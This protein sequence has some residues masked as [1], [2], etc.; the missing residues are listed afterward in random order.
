[1]G[2]RSETLRVTGM[3]C[4]NCARTIEKSVAKVA[5]VTDARVN[6]A[7]EKLTAV[8]DPDAVDLAAIEQAVKKAGYGVAPQPAAIAPTD[9]GGAAQPVVADGDEETNARLRRFWFSAAFTL[10]LFALAMGGMLVGFEPAWKPGAEFLLALPIAMYAAV[11]FYD[12]AWKALRNKS[13][14]MDT[15]VALGAGSAFAY[16]AIEVLFPHVFPG[17]ALYFE[18]GAV[19]VTLI[20]LGK[21]FEARSKSRASSAIKRLLQLGAKSA[22]VER[23]GAWVDVPIEQ[24]RPGDRM[25]VKPGERVPTDGRVVSGQSAVDESMVTGESLPVEKKAGDE[26]VGATVLQNGSLVVE[27]TR[28]GSDTMLAQ[29]VR[30]VEDAQTSR[31]PVERLVDQVSRFFV[32]VV[33]VVAILAGVAWYVLGQ[34][35]IVSMGYEPLSFSLL[36]TIAVLIIACPCAMGLAT[37]TAI[38]VGTGRGAEAGILLKG[39]DVLERARKVGV[40]LLDKTGTITRGKPDVTDVIPYGVDEPDLLRAAAAVESRSEHPLASAIVARAKAQGLAL[41]DVAQFEAIGG[42][43]VR[44]Q[45]EGEP[46]AVGRLSYLRSLGTDTTQAEAD[47]ARLQSEGKSVVGVAHGGTLVGLVAIADT[48]KPESAEAVRRMRAMGLDVVMVTGDNRGSAEAIARQVGITTVEAEVLPQD[49]A[50]L[51]KKYQAA[52]QQVAFAGDGINDAPALAQSDLGIAMGAG[53]DIAIETGH[54]VLVGDDLRDVAAAVDLSRKTLRKIW[55]NL[56]WAFGYNVLLIPVAAGLLFAVPVF[57]ERL[58][59][60]PMLAAGAMAFSSVSVVLNST[61]LGRWR[62]PAASPTAGARARDAAPARA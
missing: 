29:I 35:L 62:K 57:G 25:M 14:N 26:V 54:V 30:L 15:L 42:Q 2:E 37:P 8:F 32:P 19:I 38:M 17:M 28:V 43:G 51:V 61:L 49:K 34:E 4:A 53:T 60:H 58:L 18:T 39:G 56:G 24:V 23:D 10:P 12:G 3:T 50:A 44:A 59:L 33:I 7:T 40:V 16:S 48:V 41:P 31:A 47:A 27:A 6:L 55:Q 36:V 11:P 46:I 21:Y 1:M 52:G 9:T 5:G 13:A 22:R 20:L 45:V